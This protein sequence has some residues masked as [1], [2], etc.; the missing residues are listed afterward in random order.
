LG[1]HFGKRKVHKY[2]FAIDLRF[3]ISILQTKLMIYE[4]Q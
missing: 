1:L 2:N 3:F 4:N